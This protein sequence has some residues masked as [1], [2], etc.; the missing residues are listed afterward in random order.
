MEFQD[1][2]GSMKING[3][4]LLS[5]NK[6]NVWRGIHISPY[7]KTVEC[8][9][10]KI[11]DFIINMDTYEVQKYD[12][13]PGSP[14]ITIPAN[15]GHGFI[16][17]ENNSTLK[18]ILDG[19][20]DA[21]I[22]KTIHYRHP[23]F[24]NYLNIPYDIEYIMSEKDAKKN[25]EEIEY[26]V[27][28]GSGFLG[29]RTCEVLRTQNKKFMLLSTRLE[30]FNIL[31][32]QLVYYKPKYLICAAGISGRPTTQWCEENK[33]DTIYTNLTLQLQLV[34]ICYEL[35]IHITLYGSGAVFELS[36]TPIIHSTSELGDINIK[37]FYNK[38]RVLLE[39][40][41]ISYP[42][43]LYLRILYPI[44]DDNDP[45]CFKSK[46]WNRIPDNISMTITYLPT[47]LPLLTEL[48]ESNTT[49]IYNFVNK[50]IHLSEISS[51]ICTYK[52]P[53]KYLLLEKPFEKVLCVYCVP[54]HEHKYQEHINNF[55]N[56]YINK[57]SGKNHDLLIVFND[58][59]YPSCVSK[60]INELWNLSG[61]N[62]PTSLVYKYTVYSNEG[63]DIGSYIQATKEF[64][65][66]YD[67]IVYIST[68]TS[69]KVDY[70]LKYMIDPFLVDST[71]AMVGTH[72]SYEI[73]KH[74]RTNCFAISKK[75]FDS[76]CSYN[77]KQDEDRYNFEH[78]ENNI[79]QKVVSLGYKVVIVIKEGKII[80]ESEWPNYCGFRIEDQSDLI[81][82]DKSSDSFD[83]SNLI[84]CTYPGYNY[85]KLED[86]N[87]YIECLV[88]H[89]G[90]LSDKGTL[91]C[92]LPV[93]DEIMLPYRR[94]ATDILEIGVQFGG[95][96][97]L[98]VNYF[99][100]AH[101]HG[102]DPTDQL[103]YPIK[104]NKRCTYYNADGY[105][106]EF[107]TK[108]FKENS[109]DIIIDDGPHTLDSMLSF[110][111]IFPSYLK[112][113]GLLIIEDIPSMEWI[114]IIE[115]YIDKNLMHKTKIIDLRS[116]KN[117][118]DDLIY[119]AYKI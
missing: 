93:Y 61:I 100:R 76:I 31:K 28:G 119:I 104:S 67:Y 12:L 96:M 36:D 53:I 29:S 39:R 106:Q 118:F 43:V 11:T 24:V 42:N 111:K 15:Y 40:S 84:E 89:V 41:V 79:Y 22:E 38:M 117:R 46:M 94:K 116:I 55:F 88:P 34:H 74:I 70:W 7:A 73:N 47:L 81:V 2:R 25:W 86:L 14:P 13:I 49:G 35:G 23:A 80:T 107:I 99:T 26:V 32:Q 64:C 87:T 66:Y 1:H 108:T 33:Q 63:K 95:S 18:Y 19:V 105:N 77:I 3:N 60:T 52:D 10:G 109:M 62:P 71:I 97:T 85:K 110:A 16:S 98:W 56:D 30:N 68:S 6:A 21:Q 57:Q 75:I 78:R 82:H 9:S 90:A 102:I 45:K 103:I 17:H 54:L 113:G 27:L 91:H 4:E 44:S 65:N 50:T 72:G 5:I 101:I 92:Y 20:F 115:S 83:G 69:I 114:P 8:L 37:S 58:S 112:S 51:N 59:Y 48:I